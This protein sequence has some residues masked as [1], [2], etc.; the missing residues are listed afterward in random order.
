MQLNGKFYVTYI[1]P[2]LNLL[3]M[4]SHYGKLKDILQADRK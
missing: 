4:N 1:L 3:L 2:Q